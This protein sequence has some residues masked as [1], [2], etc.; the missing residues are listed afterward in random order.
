MF[1]KNLGSKQL[2]YKYIKAKGEFHMN[3]PEMA[4][5]LHQAVR[6][7]EPLAYEERVERFGSQQGNFPPG[8]FF[9]QICFVEKDGNLLKIAIPWFQ[10]ST[11]STKECQKVLNTSRIALGIFQAPKV[12]QLEGRTASHA[13]CPRY[14]LNIL[15]EFWWRCMMS[16]GKGNF[17]K[18]HYL[19]HFGVYSSPH[20]LNDY[21]CYIYIK[22]DTMI[23]WQYVFIF[24]THTYM[25]I[26]IYILH[27]HTYIY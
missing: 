15:G 2:R 4:R 19:I 17:S 27:I 20:F 6:N 23:Q 8:R 21:I 22:Y 12:E 13:Q 9:A 24:I 10:V 14:P 25:S 16:P 26:Y 7:N 3:N 5:A 11:F 1:F 18:C